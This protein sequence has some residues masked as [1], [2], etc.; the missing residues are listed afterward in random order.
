MN[1]SPL[2]VEEVLLAYPKVKQAF[3]FGVPDHQRG[4]N[5]TAVIELKEDNTCTEDEIRLHCRSTIASYKV[6]RHIEFRKKEQ[7]PMTRTGKVSKPELKKEITEKL[8]NCKFE[9]E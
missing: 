2:E 9:T 3:V 7:L 4:E 8:G 6:P 1:V 5:V